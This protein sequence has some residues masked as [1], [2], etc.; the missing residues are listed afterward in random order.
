MPANLVA[1]AA[2]NGISLNWDDNTETDLI[3]YNVYRSSSANGTFTKLNGGPLALSQFLDAA[4]PSGTSFYRVSAVDSSA[5][6]SDFA[7]A[8][9][10]RTSAYSYADIGNAIPA[11]SLTTITEGKDYD[12]KAGGADVYGTSDSFGFGSQSVTGD[13]DVKVRLASL[14]NS[15]ALAKAGL[16]ARP[17]C[18]RPAAAMRSSM[19]RPRASVSPTAR[20]ST[21]GPPPPAPARSGYP[22]H[23]APPHPRWQP[24]HRVS[25]HRRR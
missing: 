4:A 23:L 13:F 2:S 19:P 12:L 3:G 16:M 10:T 18:P 9:A 7:T 24:L 17:S 6:E 11:G 22:E 8:N 15:D 5:N 14:S 25:Q 20:T 21:A 1:T